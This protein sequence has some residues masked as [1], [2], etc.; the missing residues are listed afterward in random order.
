VSDFDFSSGMLKHEV[1]KLYFICQFLQEILPVKGHP[2]NLKRNVSNV[3]L[4]DT[5]PCDAGSMRLLQESVTR[6]ASPPISKAFHHW[7]YH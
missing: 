7:R 3:A 5:G 2:N 6:P 4:S 1:I